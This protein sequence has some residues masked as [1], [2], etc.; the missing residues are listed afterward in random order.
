MQ[1]FEFPHDCDG[2]SSMFVIRIQLKFTHFEMEHN[3]ECSYDH[4]ELYDGNSADSSILGRYCGT[5]VPDPILA[6]SNRLF[7][8]FYSDTTVQRTGFQVR[9]LKGLPQ[10]QHQQQQQQ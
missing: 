4:V 10:Q 7:M 1:S 3:Q 6:S 2:L 9:D 8:R 5:K